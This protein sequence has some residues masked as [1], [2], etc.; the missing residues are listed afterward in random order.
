M[1]IL[2]FRIRSGMR[3]CAEFRLA[4]LDRINST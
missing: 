1:E 2:A 4:K 3:L